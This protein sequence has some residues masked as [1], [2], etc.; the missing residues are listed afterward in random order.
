MMSSMISVQCRDMM[1]IFVTDGLCPFHIRYAITGASGT[2]WEYLPRSSPAD[3]SR[4]LVLNPLG[5]S[6][7]LRDILALRCSS[8]RSPPRNVEALLLLQWP[9]PGM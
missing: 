6:E 3:G 7:P 9:G 2:D 4:L 1:M 5:W 8:A